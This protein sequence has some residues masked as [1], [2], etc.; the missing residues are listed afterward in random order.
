MSECKKNVLEMIEE[1]LTAL[2][3]ESFCTCQ[4]SYEGTGMCNYCKVRQ[5]LQ[6]ARACIITSVDRIAAMRS[7]MVAIQGEIEDKIGQLLRED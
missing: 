5:G 4:Y 7:N 1:A 3:R 6:A 2:R